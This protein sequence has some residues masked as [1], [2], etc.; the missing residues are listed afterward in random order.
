MPSAR[1]PFIPILAIVLVLALGALAWWKFGS[2]SQQAAPAATAVASL[3]DIEIT[4]SALG[5]IG[6]KTYV[7]VG[8]QLSG[9][10]EKLHV[11]VGDRVEQDTLLAEIDPRIYESQ[12]EGNRARVDS[13]K[14]QLSERQ[15]TL[16]LARA[17]H[18]RNQSV[19]E[20]GL[21]AREVLDTS[22][23]QLK[24][25]EAQI[26]SLRAQLK[27]AQSTLDG[28]IANLGYSRIYAPIAGT[29][30]SLTALEGQTLNANQTAPTILRIA[31]LDTMTVTAQVA[32]ADIV[33]IQ[34][35]MSAWFTT[36]GQPDRRWQG[37]VRQI[38]PTPDIV[39]EV[40]LYKVLI[41]VDNSDGALLPDMTAQVFFTVSEARGVVTVPI[42]AV[43]SPPQSRGQS[44][45]RV[46]GPEGTPPRP[47]QT[48]LRDRE[49]VE[50]VSGLAEGDT[51]LLPPT[52]APAAAGGSMRPPMGM[53]GPGPRR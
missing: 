11:D 23:A 46:P 26:V 49:K 21:I 5:K 18:T 10:L 53:M 8:A 45:V 42:A 6:P 52:N 15:A 22:A 9:Q 39:N 41:D 20:R 3:G 19:A 14:A 27:E 2:K 12:V 34:T 13:L 24:Q 36:L 37:E 16:E 4:V 38:Q 51:V 7:D 30:V 48:G 40:V 28:N 33:R 32:E 35:G 29:V 31:D 25:A 1:R 50:I 17:T 43:F 47:V 44:F